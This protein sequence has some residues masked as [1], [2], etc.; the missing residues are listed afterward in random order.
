MF[1]AAPSPVMEQERPR[2]SFDLLMAHSSTYVFKDSA[3]YDAG[4]DLE[5]SM[6]EV[7]YRRLLSRGLEL[8]VSLP[9][10]SYN[11]GIFDGLID[12]FHSATGLP[13]YGRSSRPRNSYY[14]RVT[15][16][17]GEE[18]IEGRAGDIAP[19]DMR[20]H[21]K[22]LVSGS[23]R[24]ALS[25][26]GFAEAPTGEAEAGYGNGSW[27]AGLS[28]LAGADLGGSARVFLNIGA[29]SPGDIKGGGRI[30]LKEYAYAGAGVSYFFTER[31][32]ATAQVLGQGSP[33]DTGIRELDSEA[34]LFTVGARCSG[35]KRSWEAS[36]TEDPNT[37]GAPDIM[38]GIKVSQAL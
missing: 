36:F 34:L 32:S 31:I 5:A 19:G 22:W 24:W 10:I 20:A 30:P 25:L 26:M 37:A 7:L 21:L 1:I 9:L 11:S 16:P 38:I 6:A 15:G 28:L 2:N 29:I 17:G 18:V 3:D 8:G 23:E 14:F 27:D 35:E 33:Y 4:I 12:S 13:D